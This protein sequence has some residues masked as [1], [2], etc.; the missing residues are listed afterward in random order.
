MLNFS[1]GLYQEFDV[2]DEWQQ[3]DIINGLYITRIIEDDMIIRRSQGPDLLSAKISHVSQLAK[4]NKEIPAPFSNRNN[5]E[6]AVIPVF[7]SDVMILSQTCDIAHDEQITVARVRSFEPKSNAE[8]LENIRRG[9]VMN[10]FYLPNYPETGKESFSNL[11]EITVLSKKLLKVHEKQRK[12]SL[13]PEGLRGFQFF[14]ERFFGRE[15]MPDGVSRIITEFCRRLRETEIG[16]KIERIYYD[17][18]TDQISLLVAL[19]EE[20][21]NVQT[22]VETAS[23]LAAD[24]IEHSYELSAAHQLMDNISLRDIEG[25]REFR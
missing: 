23:N 5:K 9:Y 18:S 14:I 3:G 4:E 20:D 22:A 1:D 13:S 8:F 6:Y 25:F 15:A 7:K 12:K 16:D 2:S 24:S 17:Y 19:N 10:A 21:D 11:A